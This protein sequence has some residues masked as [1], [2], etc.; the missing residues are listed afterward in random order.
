L[1]YPDGTLSIVNG[2]FYM[3]SET[4]PEGDD[5]I[6]AE[7]ESTVTAKLIET[8]N[9][10]TH[11]W[12]AGTLRVYIVPDLGNVVCEQEFMVEDGNGNPLAFIDK[13]GNMTLRGGLMVKGMYQDER[14]DN[15]VERGTQP[16]GHP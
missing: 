12:I 13:D 9:G 16:V 5:I 4:L 15:F 2:E 11:F 6:L 8:E 14:A 10:Q 1:V 3:G 7:C